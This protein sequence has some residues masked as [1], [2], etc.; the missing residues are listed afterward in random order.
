MIQIWFKT[1]LLFF[2]LLCLTLNIDFFLL[3]SHVT[4]LIQLANNTD[5]FKGFG[6]REG[7]G[8]ARCKKKQKDKKKKE[9]EME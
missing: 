6:E 8:D 4:L 3:I 9:A 1:W 5:I 7:V 2:F